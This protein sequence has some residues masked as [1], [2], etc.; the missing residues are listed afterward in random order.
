MAAISTIRKNFGLVIII[1][2]VALFAFIVGDALQNNPLL[3]QDTSDRSIGVIGD[4][5]IDYN[6]FANKYNENLEGFKQ[7]VQRTSLTPEEEAQ[8]RD[9]TWQQLVQENTI[10]K[11]Y[12]RIGLDISTDELEYITIQQP[13]Q[14]IIQSF[15]NP[16]TNQFERDRL[17]YFIQNL[18]TFEPEVRNNWYKYED[19]LVDDRKRRKYF[20]LIKRSQFVTDIEAQHRGI[21]EAKTASFD[22]ISLP[23]SSIAD[24]AV[25]LSDEELRAYFEKHK[26]RYEQE[27]KRTLEYVAFDLRPTPEDSVSAVNDIENRKRLF[28][29]TSKDS[30]FVVRNT[31]LPFDTGYKKLNAINELYVQD[32]LD[33]DSGDVIGPYYEGGNLILVKVLAEKED[34]A[35]LYKASHILIQPEGNADEDTARAM[36]EARDILKQIREGADFAEMARQHSDDQSNAAKGGDLGWF[37]ENSMVK[38]FNDAVMEGSKGDMIVAKTSFGAHIIHITED[39]EETMFR[40]AVVERPITYSGG[41]KDK[42]FRKANT[43]R[44]SVEQKNDF[45]EAAAA[46]NL[47]KRTLEN[48][49]PQDATLVGIQNPRPLIKWA[50]EGEE[51]DVSDVIDLNDRLVVAK[52]SAVTEEGTA[53]LDD[54]REEVELEAR[55]EKKREM[56][57]A[58]IKEANEGASTLE[59][60]AERLNTQVKQANQVQFSARA[61]PQ[62]GDEPKVIGAVFGLSPG[63]LSYP[64]KGQNAVFQVVVREFQNEQVP[65]DLQQP[66]TAILSD[67]EGRS[68]FQIMEA[69]E[70][71]ADIK[72][73]RYKFY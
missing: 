66:K 39:P 50:Y 13:S 22:Y 15:T 54:V 56:L 32:V 1:I 51:G 55:A 43:F 25:E 70:D 23:L 35:S 64:I 5:E 26:K 17:I 46:S 48:V 2:M 11:E 40:L 65:E 29:R 36:Q 42:V 44:A 12:S 9:Q 73:Y 37:A 19:F 47:N 72:D 16:E 4:E 62:I 68:Q 61:L 7:R 8:V 34:T 20:E 27:K 60:V 14:D 63:L 52:I 53:E 6:L 3:F 45:S 58:R 49:G 33:A 71:K 41:T 30:M 18:S 28:K 31:D 21:S 59:D 67:R 69:L 10:G 57:A 24:T 38:P